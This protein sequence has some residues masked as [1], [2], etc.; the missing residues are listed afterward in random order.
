MFNNLTVYETLMYSAL[1]RLPSSMLKSS[2]IDRV[3]E[4]IGQLGLE[5]C[6]NTRIG[7]RESRG[8]SGGISS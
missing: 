6:R 3:N 4:I 2:K 1:L 7:S 8:I 5:D